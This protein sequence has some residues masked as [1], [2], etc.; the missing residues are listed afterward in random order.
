[1]KHTRS[2][3]WLKWICSRYFWPA[4]ENNADQQICARSLSLQKT[5]FYKCLNQFS[6]LEIINLDEFVFENV[7]II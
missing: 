1:M 5:Q 4:F 6:L 3:N 2:R 7:F